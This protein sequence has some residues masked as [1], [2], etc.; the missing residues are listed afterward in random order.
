[1]SA[2]RPM[3]GSCYK[4]GTHPTRTMQ[5]ACAVLA[6]LLTC[7][8]STTAVAWRGWVPA[9]LSGPPAVLY[10]NE[11]QALDTLV[12][13]DLVT[14]DAACARSSV[15]ALV[16]APPG[17][18]ASLGL[19][20]ACGN[21]LE[22]V[23]ALCGAL[24]EALGAACVGTVTQTPGCPAGTVPRRGTALDPALH[25]CT[26][27]PAG[28]TTRILV[29]SLGGGPLVEVGATGP[30]TA[31]RATASCVAVSLRE[32]A[33]PE[34]VLQQVAAA[35]TVGSLPPQSPVCVHLPASTLMWSGA[36]WPGGPDARGCMS[37]PTPAQG[38]AALAG[39]ATAVLASSMPDSAR[40]HGTSVSLGGFATVA[41]LG[42]DVQVSPAAVT[43]S[44]VCLSALVLPW[45]CLCATA[46]GGIGPACTVP[47]PGCSSDFV[48]GATG[49]PPLGRVQGVVSAAAGAAPPTDPRVVVW[50]GGTPPAFGVPTLAAVF[51]A[52]SWGWTDAAGN[53]PLGTPV[54]VPG[55]CLAGAGP[56]CGNE[57]CNPEAAGG[58]ELA[59]CGGP[60]VG[61]C[62][63]GS[64]GVCECEPG[65]WADPWAQCLACL[66][67][68]TRVSVGPDGCVWTTGAC[69]HGPANGPPGHPRAPCSGSGSCLLAGNYSG[70]S[71]RAPVCV[72][73]KG[74]T[75]TGCEVVLASASA[76]ASA[77]ADVSTGSTLALGADAVCL[78]DGDTA[79]GP[80]T[81]AVC[82]P[83]GLETEPDPVA[84]GYTVVVLPVGGVTGGPGDPFLPQSGLPD[85][86]DSWVVWGG[87]AVSLAAAA[88]GVCRAARG[89]VA[90]QQGVPG[91]VGGADSSSGVRGY[92]GYESGDVSV[93]VFPVWMDEAGAG[94]GPPDGWPF[95][96]PLGW[97]GLVAARVAAT[98][99]VSA[100]MFPNVD[101][102]VAAGVGVV[103]VVALCVVPGCALAPPV[104]RVP[105]AGLGV[106]RGGAAASAAAVTLG[107]LL[108]GGT[109]WAGAA[110]GVDAGAGVSGGPSRALGV[111][112]GSTWGAAAP[113][114]VIMW[115]DLVQCGAVPGPLL[116]G[117]PARTAQEVVD[118]VS[119]GVRLTDLLGG[120][121]GT[122]ASPWAGLPSPIMF[123]AWVAAPGQPAA[124]VWAMVN[125]L[126]TVVQEVSAYVAEAM[127]LRD[128]G[129]VVG[130]CGRGEP[131][132]LG[133]VLGSKLWV[134]GGVV[135][136]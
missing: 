20:P 67:G 10:S 127:V 114:E 105:A 59:E 54:C 106:I 68:A 94:V 126:D 90:V 25:W 39:V 92:G 46:W 5:G 136:K 63:P 33:A 37:G 4:G 11:L 116:C 119:A 76:S 110:A 58:Y 21:T 83:P 38:L 30:W 100:A 47:V 12:L 51:L 122:W 3:L 32:T 74:F 18:S 42:G 55:G 132:V 123:T 87:G 81:A 40:P 34:T 22:A 125:L 53:A 8:P 50:R 78:R 48:G 121:T 57:V 86:D 91:Y 104:L 26:L 82:A 95:T 13:Q 9:G 113:Q 41:T 43:E 52:G 2:A 62:A 14:G 107:A 130:L 17:S 75:G 72:C 111:V 77:S 118:W 45:E 109:G 97:P 88:E 7:V 98:H 89:A 56:T 115:A 129:A 79:V 23:A 73:A 124:R 16:W 135:A 61:H 6:V 29:Q 84:C 36:R 85:P 24:C 44:A 80:R 117:V 131:Q 120:G 101:G 133:S 19:A 96:A 103:P 128:V 93:S 28:N 70:F 27:V 71:L 1:M 49:P 99:R 102:N 66:P 65:S 64:P 60:G 31:P 35:G 112:C 134:A 108:A 69:F 15:P